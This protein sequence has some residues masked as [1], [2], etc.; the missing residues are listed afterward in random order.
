MNTQP[1]ETE[2]ITMSK[3]HFDEIRAAWWALCSLESVLDAG[4][5]EKY[6]D[7]VH[8]LRPIN[9]KISNVMSVVD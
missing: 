6:N 1:E 2:P 8:L 7:C 5:D 4:A 9:E 3:A